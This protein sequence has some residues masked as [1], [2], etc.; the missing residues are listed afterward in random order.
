MSVTDRDTFSG[1]IGDTN[2]ETVQI[3]A[4]EATRA[5]LTIDDGTTGNSPAEYTITVRGYNPGVER[6]QFVWEETTRTDRSWSFDAVG[7]SIEVEI[8]N[9]SG[10]SAT[11]EFMLE[12]RDGQ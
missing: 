2:S 9:T 7:G 10:G 12:G 5:H 3:S 4:S 6:F 1:S 8:T 11:Y